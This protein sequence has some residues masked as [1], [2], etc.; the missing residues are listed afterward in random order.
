MASIAELPKPVQYLGVVLAGILVTAGLY[1]GLFRRLAEQNRLAADKLQARVAEVNAL[2]KYDNSLRDLDNQIAGLK[3]QLEIQKSIVP[4]AQEADQFMHL[5]QD[6]AQGAGIEIRRWT[7]K[8]VASHEF[9][10]EVPFDLELDGPY[11]SMLNFFDRVA[12]LQRIVNVSSLQLAALRDAKGATT[13]KY[14]Y[15]AQESVTGTCTA[16]TFFSVEHPPATPP[17]KAGAK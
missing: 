7:A 11:Y 16:S 8:P 1:F 4:D 9:Y 14:R 15:A 5:L 6:T 10:T 13:G 17:G 2:R 3:Q 12:R